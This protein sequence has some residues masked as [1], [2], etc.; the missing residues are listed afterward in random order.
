MWQEIMHQ[1]TT[2]PGRD[3][4]KNAAPAEFVTDEGQQL[5]KTYSIHAGD[6]R[7]YLP[8]FV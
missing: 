3:D 1:S 4:S 8:V 5:L 6:Q 7:S 2:P